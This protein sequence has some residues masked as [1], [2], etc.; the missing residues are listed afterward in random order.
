M[1]SLVLAA[2]A[3]QETS[4]SA[5]NYAVDM[6]MPAHLE[7]VLWSDEFN[8]SRLD[9]S[10][11]QYDTSR[12]KEGWYNKELQYYAANRLEN[13]R[14]GGGNL[15]I[16]LR[17]DPQEI[18][19][20]PDW[21]KQKYSSAKI[22]TQGK[23]A[24]KYGFFEARAKLPCTRGSWPAFWMM[25]TANVEWPQGGEIDILEHIGAQPGVVHAN[26]H[27][28]K[29][30]HTKQNGRGA[31]KPLPT[32]CSDFHRYQLSWTEDE[33]LIGVDDRAYMRVRN[34][35]PGDRGA[36]PFDKPFYLILN[37][38]M[39]GDWAGSKGIDDASLPQKFEVDYVRVWE[40]PAAT[41]ASAPATEAPKSN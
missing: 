30:N 4:L 12:N 37:L 17:K 40:M 16:E 34:S 26:L 29:Y 18:R 31:Q 36:W 19:K 10:K 7:T 15:T 24:F 41:D 3:L 5:N 39:G 20:F 2:A 9:A 8:G 6:P 14:V 25:P 23:A 1:I 13:L 22:V 35:E 38:A 27:T 11:W 33:I 32:S 21:G 28:G